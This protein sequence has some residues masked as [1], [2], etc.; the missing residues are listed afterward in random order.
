M[1]YYRLHAKTHLVDDPMPQIRWIRVFAW[2]CGIHSERKGCDPESTASSFI[3][4][5]VE[6]LIE[7][8]LQNLQRSAV[9]VHK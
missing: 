6:K 7:C 3:C 5:T 8:V 4:S 9:C 1:D 2:S